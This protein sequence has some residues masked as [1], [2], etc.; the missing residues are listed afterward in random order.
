LSLSLQ[1]F[2]VVCALIFG[3]NIG[4]FLNVVIW[5]LP[6][7][8]SIAVPRWSYCPRCEHRLGILDLVPIV[9]FV[10]LRGRCRYCGDRIS[11]RYP[12]I[13]LL[14]ACLFAIVAWK[15]YGSTVDTVCYC[16]FVAVLVCVFFIDLEHFLIPD[17][18]N[19]TAALI[20]FAHNGLAVALRHPGQFGVVA[21]VMLPASVIGFGVYAAIVYTVGLLS[22]MVLARRNPFVSAWVYISDNVVDWCEIALY[23]AA[24]VIPPLRRFVRP[25]EPLEG[26]TAAEIEADEDAGGMGSGDGK[27]AAAIG[28]N[29]YA[30]L[31]LQSFLLAI[32]MG[33][34]A[35]LAMM[36]KQ[37]R[38]LGKTAMPFGPYMAAGAFLSLIFGPNLVTLW[39]WYLLTA[40]GGPQSNITPTAGGS[41][42]HLMPAP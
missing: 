23:Y 6:R 11:W 24:A 4:S 10:A 35:G 33:S 15:Y 37:R 12:A 1:A 25:C 14:T 28:A 26:W 20:G 40:A 17:G 8:G 22:Y 34:I 31:A 29:L 19:V 41:Q 9:S 42:S 3:I 38:R 18:L 27:L 36:I 32:F 21:G 2:T 13:E 5:R 39:Q 30:L 7:G 16:L